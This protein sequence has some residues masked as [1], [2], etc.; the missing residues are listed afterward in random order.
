MSEDLD[1]RFARMEEH[2][3]KIDKDII[4]LFQRFMKHMDKEEIA[5]DKLYSRLRDMEKEL[6]ESFKERDATI[7][8]I[9]SSQAKAMND[10]KIQQ[11]K[12]MAYMTAT[13]SA[14]TIFSQIVLKVFF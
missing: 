4:D 6:S 14:M 9:E 3:A 8:S 2:Q 10:L 11:T 7:Q 1:I 12:I 5:F 13:F